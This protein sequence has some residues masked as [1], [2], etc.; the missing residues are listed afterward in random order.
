MTVA[1]L[2]RVMVVVIGV[3]KPVR[4]HLHVD[5]LGVLLLVDTRV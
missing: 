2:G 3:V 5:N 1:K 4:C